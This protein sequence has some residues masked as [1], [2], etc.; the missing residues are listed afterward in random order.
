MWRS[1]YLIR[2]AIG[3][4]LVVLRVGFCS[5]ALAVVDQQFL[6][7]YNSTANVGAGNDIDWAQTFTVGITGQLVGFDVPVSRGSSIVQPLLYDIRQT[8]G[9][10]PTDADFGINVLASGLVNAQAIPILPQLPSQA[11]SLTHFDVSD[12]GLSVAAGDVLAIVLRSD[13]PGTQG[14]GITYTWYGNYNNSYTRGVAFYRDATGTDQWNNQG[15][16]DMEFETEVIP[17]PEPA[18]LALLALGAVGLLRRR[19]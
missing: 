9:G 19:R 17:V 12:A 1:S 18:T 3:V 5:R 14:P 7:Q 11:P 10:V 15:G 2:F 4:S 16:I 6:V 8:V 13:D